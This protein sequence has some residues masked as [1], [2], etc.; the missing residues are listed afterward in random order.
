MT[1]MEKCAG[2]R[3]LLDDIPFLNCSRCSAKYHH[4]C[5]NMN[6]E[7]FNALDTTY[8]ECWICVLCRC[9]ERKG[10]DNTNTPV[11]CT[12][13]P[14]YVT[15]R[16]KSRV[17]AAAGAKTS[18]STNFSPLAT[19]THPGTTSLPMPAISTVLS[20]TCVLDNAPITT[21]DNPVSP[22]SNTSVSG[23]EKCS[24]ISS[25]GM[26]D[27]IRAELLNAFKHEFLPQLLE[28]RNVVASLENSMT[29]YSNELL[30][31]Q[32]A[33]AEQS[34]ALDT[35]RKENQALRESCVSLSSRLAQLDQQSR[36]SNVEIQCVPEHRQENLLNT[37]QQ[38]AK[39]IKCPISENNIHYCTRMAKMNGAS[40]RPRSILVKFSSPRLRDEFLA[41]TSKFNKSHK[42][43]KLNTSH[44]GFGADKKKP[45][46]VVE[47]LT[48][49][50]KAL[51]AAARQKAKE[52]KYQFV[53]V[54]DGRIFMRKS[55][56]SAFVHV[57]NLDI[58]NK[59]S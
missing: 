10:G 32:A 33:Q 4:T 15:I 7:D 39:T 21:T 50:Y 16:T 18:P 20:G 55:E 38:L 19:T 13:S 2:C 41:A 42:D 44:L 43:D 25:S 24:C 51:H 34:A 26:R 57:K 35:I 30:K 47:N 11:R 23:V 28:V 59:L 31:V 3:T 17:T 22:V 27:I 36:S 37:I 40:P 6:T 58:L 52:L 29:F 12:S 49:E 14:Q 48:P 8:K 45:I 53:W 46:Y 1:K 5:L 56:Q 54:R 9:N